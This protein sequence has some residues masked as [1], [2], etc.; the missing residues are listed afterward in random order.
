MIRALIFDFDGLILETEEPT[1]K[2]WQEVYRS[3]G[4][5]LPFST[6]SIMVGTTQS[7]FDPLKELQKRV[8]A[9]VDWG[10]VET[11]RQ[12]SENAFIEAQSILPGVEGYLSDARRLGLQIGLASNSSCQWVSRHLTRIGLVD[13]FDCICTSDEV[14]HLKPDPELYLSALGK[15]KVNA[16]EAIAFEDSPYGI[17]SAKGAGLFCVAVPNALTIQLALTQADFQLS[18]LE[19][20]PLEAL[21]QK[22]NALKT[23][24]AAF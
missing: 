19:E 22:F 12:E 18:S 1:F 17:C 10:V 6:W 9:E 23:Q 15:L 2:S 16:Q 5:S 20:M 13:R 7:G 8:K 21:L 24:R 14:Q 4:H 11:R 3:F